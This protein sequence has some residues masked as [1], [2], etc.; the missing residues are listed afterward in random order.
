MEARAAAGRR[1]PFESHVRR[2]YFHVK[3]LEEAQL[4]NWRKYLAFEE[5]EGDRNAVVNLY[6][7]CLIPCV[8]FFF[9]FFFFFF[10]CF[11]SLL[12]CAC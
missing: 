8:S 7:R 10:F 2:P 12:L 11:W 3:P 4:E 9:F 5:A 6:E 1:K